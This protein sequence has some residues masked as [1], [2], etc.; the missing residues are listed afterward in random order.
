MENVD[1]LKYMNMQLYRR[2]DAAAI[3]DNAQC[4]NQ[5]VL[6]DPA[7]VTNAPAKEHDRRHKKYTEKCRTKTGMCAVFAHC[8][9]ND[10]FEELSMG[11]NVCLTV[12]F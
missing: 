11:F 8:I 3:D 2:C 1:T 12:D 5:R 7:A 6:L 10:Q 9:S 4:N